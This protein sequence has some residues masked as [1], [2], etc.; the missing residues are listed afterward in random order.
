MPVLAVVGVLIACYFPYM[1]ML[2]LAFATSL[3]LARHPRPEAAAPDS[4]TEIMQSS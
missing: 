3:W 1:I 4:E 2:S